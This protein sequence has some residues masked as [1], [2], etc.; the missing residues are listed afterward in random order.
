MPTMG[1]MGQPVMMVAMPGGAGQTVGAVPATGMMM[2][3]GMNM[4]MTSMQQPQQS[5]AAQG[6]MSIQNSQGLMGAQNQASMSINQMSMVRRFSNCRIYCIF[7]KCYQL[8][9][10]LTCISSK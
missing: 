3:M 5:I 10:G 6:I 7:N 8:L 2:A 4:G 1:L 9:S